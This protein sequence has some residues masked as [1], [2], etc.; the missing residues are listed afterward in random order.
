[1]TMDKSGMTLTEVLVAVA[2]FSVVAAAIV[3]ALLSAERTFSGGS[4]QAVLTAELRRALDRMAREMTESAS[5]RIQSV[6]VD[7]RSYPTVSFQVPED[8]N[9]D[10]AVIDANGSIAEWSMPITYQAGSRN[11][12]QRLVA[13]RGPGPAN[14]PE[15]L[16]NHI[17]ALSFRRRLPDVVEIS[18]TASTLTE[19]GQL[20]TRTL[21]TRVKL[22]N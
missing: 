20:Q 4:N 15:I 10:G 6:P 17:T 7:G 18:L 3:T 2:V 9:G 1:M 22:R 8:L 13:P 14:P 19:T 12:C 16:G 21:A 5:G 11:S